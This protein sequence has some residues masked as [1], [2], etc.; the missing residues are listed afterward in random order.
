MQAQVLIS[1]RDRDEKRLGRVK[2]HEIIFKR[3]HLVVGRSYTVE[4]IG[5]SEGAFLRGCDRMKLLIRM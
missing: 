5:K 2:E 1:G 3:L 4:C